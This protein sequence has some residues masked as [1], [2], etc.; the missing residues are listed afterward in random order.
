MKTKYEIQMRITEIKGMLRNFD[1]KEALEIPMILEEY[2]ACDYLY[3]EFETLN[4]V[5]CNGG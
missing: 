4:W 2:E 5:L 3:A 1:N